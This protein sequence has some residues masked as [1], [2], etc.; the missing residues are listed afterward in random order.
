VIRALFFALG[1]LVLAGIALVTLPARLLPLFVDPD[2]V[3]LSG[4]SGTLLKGHAAR[5]L[6]QTPAGFLHLGRLAWDVDAMSLLVL[7]PALEVRTAWGGQRVAARVQSRRGGE[8]D[9]RDLEATIDAQLLRTLAPLAVDGRLSLQ[10]DHVDFVGDLPRA[11]SGR[12]VWQDA[13]WRTATQEHLLGTYVAEVSSSDGTL[14]A[15]IDTVS[16]PVSARGAATLQ[17]SRYDLDLAI[18]G[19]ERVLA[20]EVERALRLFATPDEDSYL[21]RLDGDLAGAP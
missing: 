1:G 3:R 6:V 18:S 12:L 2:Q 13:L 5:A 20:P 17:G 11:A 7:A 19:R 9:V 10:F 4:L 21:L 14:R 16:G 15:A 8:V